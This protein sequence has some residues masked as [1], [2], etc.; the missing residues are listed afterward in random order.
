MKLV[1][2]PEYLLRSVTPPTSVSVPTSEIMIAG[3][4]TGKI[5]EGAVLEA[6]LKWREYLLLFLTDNIPF[7]DALSIYLLD[8]NLNIVDSAR[9]YHMYSTGTL[10]DLDLSLDDTVRFGFFGGI[11]WRL[12]LLPKKTFALPVISDPTGVHRSF[13]FWRMFQIDGRPM[14]DTSPAQINQP[15]P[16]TGTES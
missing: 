10:S 6:A 14:P 9:M 2:A 16:S 5:V 3:E 8:A 1:R 13:T 15:S 11:T 12:K 7:E 4:P